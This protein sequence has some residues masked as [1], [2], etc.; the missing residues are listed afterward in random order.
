MFALGHDAFGGIAARVEIAG[1]FELIPNDLD[2][3]G[4]FDR[5]AVV[6][7]IAFAIKVPLTNHVRWKSG[8]A[9]PSPRQ[10]QRL[11]SPQHSDGSTS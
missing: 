8:T 3:V 1:T 5:R 2:T 4:I 10:G 6:R 11:I 7:N 9:S